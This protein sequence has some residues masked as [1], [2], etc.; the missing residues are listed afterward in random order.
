MELIR[1]V[2]ELGEYTNEV[3]DRKE[4]HDKNLLHNEISVF[5][6]NNNREVLLQKRSENKRFNPNKWGTC[7]G[8]VGINETLEDA[9]VREI[10]EE[11][12]II[13][14]K[15]DLKILFEKEFLLRNINSS[16]KYYYYVKTDKDIKDFNIQKEELSEIKWF[17]INELIELIKNDD[18]SI[19][20]KKDRLDLLK[21]LRSIMELAPINF[22]DNEEYLRQVSKNVDFSNDEWINAIKE[23]KN[24]SIGQENLLALASIQ[25]GIPLRLIYIKNTDLDIYDGDYDEAKVLINPVIKKREGLTRFYENCASCGDYMGL[26][27][28]PYR[29]EIEY[30]DEKKQQ[31][32]EIVE[33]FVATLL[34]HEI[35]HLDGILHI[36][37]S[38]ELYNM[39]FDERKEFRKTHKYEIIK[40]EGEFIP[41]ET[42]YID[43]SN[44]IESNPKALRKIR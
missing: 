4:I 36:D 8:H 33:G 41:T 30:Y 18:D 7:A 22:F 15:K 2:N 6:I 28:R 20:L 11:L 19:T 44:A 13:V 34:S 14:D 43:I 25:V 26:V 31:H 37:K 40:E 9:A 1:V 17:K 10:E 16:V 39:D 29:I 5:I 12:G 27:E 32:K 24:R 42:N 23:L 35:D 3:L 21:R 38:I